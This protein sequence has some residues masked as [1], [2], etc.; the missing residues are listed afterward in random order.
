MT[1]HQTSSPVDKNESTLRQQQQPGLSSL[2]WTPDYQTG[3][4]VIFDKLHQGCSENSEI[5]QSVEERIRLEDQYSAGLQGFPNKLSPS[6]S[7]FNKDEGATLRQAYVSFLDEIGNQGNIHSEIAS[8]LD[9]GIRG[10][11]K[12]W[13]QEHKGRVVDSQQV[14]NTKIKEYNK[15]VSQ[16]QKAQQLYFSR[17]RQLEDT[18]S[19]PQHQRK[20]HN[21][22][23]SQVNEDE[24]DEAEGDSGNSK[25]DGF[26][27]R[28]TSMSS[29]G[30][31]SFTTPSSTASSIELAGKTYTP[32]AI[33]NLLKDMLN[34][35]PTGDYKVPIIGTYQNVSSGDEIALWARK[36]LNFNNVGIAEKFGQGLIDNG[37]LKPIGKVGSKRKFV[38]SSASYYQWQQRAIE[39]DPEAVVIVEDY[40]SSATTPTSST[41]TSATT[42][43]SAAS[44]LLSPT[45][46]AGSAISGYISG[47]LHQHTSPVQISSGRIQQEVSE[48]D[49]IYQAE[50]IELDLL[51]CE[52]EESIIEHLTFMERCELDRLRAIKKVLTDFSSILSGSLNGT[53][54]TTKKLGLIKDTVNPPSDLSYMIQN[55]KTGTFSPKVM[56]YE[57]FHNTLKCQS[58]GVDISSVQFFVPVFLEYFAQQKETKMTLDLWKQQAPLSAIHQLRNQINNGQEFDAHSILPYFPMKVAVSTLKE[59]LL[60]LQESL[61]SST[62]Y[63]VFKNTYSSYYSSNNDTEDESMLTQRKEKISSAL[64]HQQRAHITV[65]ECLINHFCELV[66]EKEGDDDTEEGKEKTIKEFSKHI[67]PYIIKP[68]KITPSTMN[69]KFPAWLVQD[70][71]LHKDSVFDSVHK[72]LEAA[73]N[74]D[75][76]TSSTSEAN[77]R[78]NVEARNK[79]LEAQAV[80]ARAARSRSGSVQSPPGKATATNNNNNQQQQRSKSPSYHGKTSSSSSSSRLSANNGLLPL[81]LSPSRHSDNED[82][83]P[84]THRK[85]R[86]SSSS[87]ITPTAGSNNITNISHKKNNS[88]Q[89]TKRISTSTDEDT[90][91]NESNTSSTASQDRS[92]IMTEHATLLHQDPPISDQDTNHK[93][94]DREF[95]GKLTTEMINELDEED[96]ENNDKT[97]TMATTTTAI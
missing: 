45:S 47:F 44:G 75:R 33:S 18:D 90:Y 74:R 15:K 36:R 94:I 24:D 64:R 21:T 46:N 53:I 2:F 95:G 22:D 1:D 59:F 96:K 10:P 89:S 35:V 29:D 82:P 20:P 6:N 51:R 48:S 62:L 69:D 12:T 37:F 16:T 80:A 91:E 39:Y 4:S 86:I 19:L 73:K 28:S 88:E 84:R 93:V 77:R 85:N 14:L 67:A 54:E 78:A 23:P 92:T 72:G 79:E 76:S 34:E 58:F 8:K 49:E 11:F 3:I 40:S 26:L 66:N 41:F 55:Y 38:N 30:T 27:S 9:R 97:P 87:L 7:G 52:L 57:N 31:K 70:L 63:D 81:T 25:L 32:K 60:E 42:N 50:V 71:I 65:L 13:S 17:C 61:I 56:V 68:R 5:L 43:S 83:P